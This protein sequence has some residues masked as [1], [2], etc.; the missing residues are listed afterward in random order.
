[1]NRADASRMGRDLCQGRSAIAGPAGRAL[2]FLSRYSRSMAEGAG[3]SAPAPGR[4][5]HILG[6]SSATIILAETEGRERSKHI[7]GL[8]V[9][10]GI[11]VIAKSLP[12]RLDPGAQLESA[13]ADVA[14]ASGSSAMA[15]ALAS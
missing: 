10:L 12:R 15:H 1:M 14:V 6:C 4:F 11:V 7:A 8:S 2:F 5:S 9:I 13:E 3:R